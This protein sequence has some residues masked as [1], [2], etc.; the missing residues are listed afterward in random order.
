ME[1]SNLTDYEIRKKQK[2]LKKLQK[3]LTSEH[4]NLDILTHQKGHY[5]VRNVEKRDA[6]AHETRKKLNEENMK[7]L[8]QKKLINDYEY[9]KRQKKIK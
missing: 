8:K 5:S 3:L 2:T 4:E 6:R 9:E 7:I 1:K